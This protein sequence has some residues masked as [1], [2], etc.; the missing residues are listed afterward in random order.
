M[1]EFKVLRKFTINNGKCQINPQPT[2]TIFFPQI[3]QKQKL[4]IIESEDNDG[5]KRGT[6]KLLFFPSFII[7]FKIT[8]LMHWKSHLMTIISTF[9]I[10]D[11]KQR[12]NHCSSSWFHHFFTWKFFDSNFGVTFRI[13][14]L[15]VAAVIQSNNHHD[16]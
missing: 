11:L 2:A 1:K 15:F 13:S 7:E 4:I 12:S 10:A 9:F 16:I 8:S 6:E 14:R 5:N 3:K